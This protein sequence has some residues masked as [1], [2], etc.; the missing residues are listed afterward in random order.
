MRF[1]SAL[2]RVHAS[3]GHRC[4]CGADGDGELLSH[5]MSDLEARCRRPPLIPLVPDRS[6]L[7]PTRELSSARAIEV[8]VESSSAR[9][10]FAILGSAIAGLDRSGARRKKK[11]LSRAALFASCRRRLSEIGA[12]DTSLGRALSGRPHPRRA[13]L[14]ADARRVGL[15]RPQADPRAEVTRFVRDF[16]FGLQVY[17]FPSIGSA[18]LTLAVAASAILHR[19]PKDAHPRAVE[20]ALLW[21][22]ALMDRMTAS[23]FGADG[24]IGDS[25]RDLGAIRR[26][27]DALA[28]ES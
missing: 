13:M 19:L 6:L 22:Q 10:P 18:L 8:L 11:S 25:A 16:V 26:Q 17:R 14:R 4:L 23:F 27:I 12:E 2:G 24:L 15:Y 5:Q 9:D 3:A 28:D 20:R 21:E 1:V 7:D